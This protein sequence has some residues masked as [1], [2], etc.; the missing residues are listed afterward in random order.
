M[1]IAIF[2]REDSETISVLVPASNCGLTLEEICAKDV[3]TGIKYKV[4]E[5][6]DLP[7]DREFRNAW[8]APDLEEDYDGVGS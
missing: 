6:T 8:V 5:D 2:Q 3:P 7:D 1:K 4:I